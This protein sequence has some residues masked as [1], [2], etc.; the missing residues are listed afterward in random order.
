MTTRITYP[1]QY[2]SGTEFLDRFTDDELEAFFTLAKT[3]VVAEVV[4]E[5]LLR[6]QMIDVASPRTAKLLTKMVAAGIL[7]AQRAQ[8]IADPGRAVEIQEYN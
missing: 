5:R 6:M 4:K 7:T 1:Y 3:S 8:Q 2:I